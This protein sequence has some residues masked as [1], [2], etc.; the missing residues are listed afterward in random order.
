VSTGQSGATVER[1]TLDR[2]FA[3]AFALEEQ[4]GR[5]G[6]GVVYRARDLRHERGVAIKILRPEVAWGVSLERFS[7]EVRL[8]ARLQHPHILPIHEWGE[9]DGIAYCVMPLVD[10]ESL[11]AR[12]TRDRQLPVPDALRIAREVASALHYAHAQGIVHR[13]VKPENILLSS[14]HAMLADFG[15]ARLTRAAHADRLTD[16]GIAVGTV[17]YMSPEQAGGDDA[18]DARSDIYSLGCVLYEMLTGEPPFGTAAL[19]RVIIARHLSDAPPPVTTVRPTVPPSVV[20]AL[21]RALAKVPA[22]RFETAGEFASALEEHA[23]SS[24]TRGADRLEPA[25]TRSRRT[26]WAAIAA[27]LVAGAA[28]VASLVSRRTHPLD[29]HKVVVFP[30]VSAADAVTGASTGWEL[31]IAIGAAL[32][33]AEPLRA[34][35]GWS[36]LPEEIRADMR[37]L[38]ASAARDIAI[39]RGARYYLDGAVTRHADSASIVLRLYDA[40]A[41]SLIAQ[42]RA[43]GSSAATLPAL[44]LGA[45]SRLLP[46]MLD[47]SRRIATFPLAARDPSA[48]ALWIQGERAYRESRFG[49]ALDF[50]RRSLQEDS[51]LV[52][53]AMRGAQ[54]ASWESRLGEA[55]SMA[56]Y[57]VA[58]R[59]LL[60]AHQA[61]FASG[62]LSYLLG[63]V[64][65]A[66]TRLSLVA[67]DDPDA[68]EPAMALAEVQHHL[69]IATASPPDSATERWLTEAVRRDSTF[70]PPLVH[71]AEIAA[72]RGEVDRADELIAALRRHHAEPTL[73][74][75][76]QLMSDCAR[77]KRP[78]WDAESAANELAVLSAAK[79]LSAHLSQPGCAEGAFRALLRAPATSAGVR[80]SAL[81]GYQGLLVATHRTSELRR[82]LDSTV[83]AGTTQALS[84]YILD[85]MAG[86][87][88]DSLAPR[89][90]DATRFARKAY[91]D[92]YERASPQTRWILGLWHAYTGDTAHLGAMVAA[93]DEA[94]TRGA[95]RERLFGAAMRAHLLLARGDTARAITALR[96]LQP[97]ARRDS[98]T[99]ELF[100]PLAVERSIL[101]RLLLA[102]GEPLDAARV[103]ESFDAAQPILHLPFLPMS[104]QIRVRVAGE[105]G[106]RDEANRLR[107]RLDALQ[108]YGL[109]AS[110]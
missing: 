41:D 75:P 6:S 85:A 32:A 40:R 31:A 10:G 69:I 53:A 91:G 20:A 24:G 100:E 5:G 58:R 46:R 9:R 110:S 38:S 62:L 98:L 89:A 27:T 93:S 7:R 61:L 29:E 101:A 13:D 77:G 78:Q 4:I 26:R 90:E 8:E 81:L 86:I 47:P 16:A 21:D 39:E 2:M 96:A 42:E 97:S 108:R 50:Y 65:S 34:I 95:R 49:D 88:R 60:S 54:A 52:L 109:K 11:R 103:A 14:G 71:L 48:V 67:R 106:R 94:A 70:T 84:L 83:A 64:D 105:L 102:R 37:R 73:V 57:A 68:V 17:S 92:A 43:T 59:D 76:L 22:D 72:R 3:D 80:W 55:E 82:T 23:P 44:A 51:S 35:D 74:R 28:V 30:L 33:H 45:T 66:V 107:A 15:L 18:V 1:A 19:P 99:W 63:E 87:E 79:E 12:L 25:I 104:L 56:R 36:R